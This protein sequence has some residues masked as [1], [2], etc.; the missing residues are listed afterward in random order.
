MTRGRFAILSVLVTALAVRLWGL[1][2]GLPYVAARPDETAV[3]GPA[4]GFLSGD[5]RPPFFEWPTLFVYA[6]AALYV[7][8]FVVTRPFAPY[9]TL[10][11]FAESRRQSLNPFLYTSRALSAV[12]GVLTVWWV[13]ALSR[14]LFDETVALVAA[15][16][17]ALCFLHVRDSHFGTTDVPMTAMVMLTVLAILR[18]RDEGTLPLA[19]AAGLAGGLASST[20]Y[21]GLGVCIPFA[22]AAIQ[23][24]QLEWRAELPTG[25]VRRFI[26]ALTVFGITLA[27]AFFGTSPYVLIDWQR[28]LLSMRGVESH[29]LQGHGLVLGRGWSY[30]ARVILPAAMGWP[31]L[32]AACAGVIGLFST[33]FR[34]A[35]VVFAF[36]ISYYLVAGRGYTVFARYIIPV[37]PFLCI[38]AGWFVVEAVRAGARH[39]APAVRIA[40]LAAMVAA[41][42]IPT[43]RKTVMLDRL[44]GTTDNREVVARALR[45][46]VA[47]DESVYQSGETFGYVP[48]VM[49]GRATAHVA[50][51]AAGTEFE[52]DL[53][54]WILLQRSP[55]VLYSSVPP[56]IE[57]L[58][59]RRYEL[60][61]V[62]PTGGERGDL[63]Y[64]QQDA[65]FLPIGRLDGV[66]RPGPAF[67]LYRRKADA[68]TAR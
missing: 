55:L 32:A 4:V 24:L 56:S 54:D 3:A 46:T 1:G 20:K 27:L 35:A 62:F 44:F 59:A 21:N 34:D 28:F 16:F 64:D 25:P 68:G 49:D 58:I 9:K 10:A 12:M 15:L 37:L 60:I 45:E 5:L 41:A 7:A 8:Y 18:W 6:V 53:P 63:V 2:F 61:K 36:P 17:L 13:Y 38:A 39:T 50:S 29:L 52:S 22:V 51:L 48:M 26:V 42:V 19:A 57:P 66:L 40:L 67:E 33:R 14:R 43:A 30:Y 65:F 23:R 11:A 47:T 31:M